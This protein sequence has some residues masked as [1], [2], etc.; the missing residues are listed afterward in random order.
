MPTP[1][2]GLIQPAGSAPALIGDLNDNADILDGAFSPS[3]VGAVG[4]LVAHLRDVTITPSYS[5]ATSKATLDMQPTWNTSGAMYCMRFQ[6]T[7]TAAG[8]A[9]RVIEIK[10]GV[11]TVFDVDVTTNVAV[12]GVSFV[13]GATGQ[14]LQI[15]A[16]GA[17]SNIGVSIVPKGSG[18]VTISNLGGV[19]NLTVVS[20]GI[21]V[22]GNSTITGTLGGLT[23]LTVASGGAAVTGNSTV[24]GDLTVTGTLS[25]SVGSDFS[26]FLDLTQISTP[27]NPAAGK[28]RVYSKS[29][30]QVY[31]LGPTGSEVPLGGSQTKTI[32]AESLTPITGCDPTLRSVGTSRYEL[33]YVHTADG[34]ASINVTI[35]QNFIGGDVTY[36]GWIWTGASASTV[37]RVYS[38]A[39]GAGASSD[40]AWAAMADQTVSSGV[41]TLQSFSVSQTL[42]AADA[43]KVLTIA[44]MRVSSSGSDTYNDTAFFRAMDIKF[45]A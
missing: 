38:V 2:L 33:A 14:N 28:V 4:A 21:T 20:G 9:S 42:A 26:S 12:N 15:K 17:D 32:A 3:G 25:A 36:K 22:T 18:T 40:T 39:I 27:A 35:P 7:H 5:G 1:N 19:T 23:G 30:N 24:T 11:N 43:G 45:G 8:A 37:W 16:I 29:D 6:V 41:G 44:I 34:Y 10:R 13:G 31:R